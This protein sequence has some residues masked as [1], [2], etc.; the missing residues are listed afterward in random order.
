ML[1]QI[2]DPAFGAPKG[3][4]FVCEGAEASVGKEAT[5]SSARSD[6]KA[7]LETLKAITWRAKLFSLHQSRVKR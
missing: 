6:G 4:S 5:A 7:R 2:D 3:R 1:V